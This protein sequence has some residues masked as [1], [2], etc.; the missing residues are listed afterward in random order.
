MIIEDEKDEDLEDI[1]DPIIPTAG[2]NQQSGDF[3]S[4]IKR[5]REIR[6]KQ[7]HHQLR[8]DLVENLWNKFGNILPSN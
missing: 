2:S 6:D 7:V 8:D 5:H 1:L 3:D 4:F